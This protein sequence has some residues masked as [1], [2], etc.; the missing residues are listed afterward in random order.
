MLETPIEILIHLSLDAQELRSVFVIQKY[1]SSGVS[2]RHNVIEGAWKFNSK[3]ACHNPT[4]QAIAAQ[5]TK[6]DLTP[7][8]CCFCLSEKMFDR[9]V[10]RK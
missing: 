9:Y 1:S 4:L 6:Q 10:P 2:P 7:V 3:E 8:S 5:N